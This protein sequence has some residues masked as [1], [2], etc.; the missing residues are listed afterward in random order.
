MKIFLV[1]IIILTPVLGFSQCNVSVEKLDENLTLHRFVFEQLADLPEYY[2]SGYYISL[3]TNGVTDGKRYIIGLKL[4]VMNLTNKPTLTPFAPRK[5]F[6]IFDNR[7]S[8]L[9]EAKDYD[10]ALGSDDKI[11]WYKYDV[12]VEL[13]NKLESENVS[14][15]TLID[16]RLDQKITISP[17]KNIF[18]EQ[19]M[20]IKKS[21]QLSVN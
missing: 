16:T 15:V 8:I 11:I 5:I 18:K 17:F 19:L 7:E 2:D 20:C 6:L 21:M 10:Y 12:N 4:Y 1:L 3:E 9:L 13:V 14:Q